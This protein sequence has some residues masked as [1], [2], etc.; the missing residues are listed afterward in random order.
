MRRELV[1]FPKTRFKFSQRRACRLV[2]IGV[3]VYWY[4][5][6]TSRDDVVIVGL[7]GVVGRYPVY[8]FGKLL[9][10]L[11][12]EGCSWNHKRVHRIYC[13]LNLNKRRRGKKRLPSRSPV[14]IA[15]PLTINGGWS[16]DF[17]SA[18]LFCCC[19][20]RTFNVV[21]DFSREA[22]AI[23]IDVGLPSERVIRVLERIVAWL[24]GYSFLRFKEIT[25]LR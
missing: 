25:R 14:K 16:M 17:M 21:D 3:S 22:L 18:S 6:D 5:P 15:L 4:K 7:Q 10:V 2:G 13:L 20:F 12:R 19:R 9:E 24:V 11:R 8:G 23:E 1:D